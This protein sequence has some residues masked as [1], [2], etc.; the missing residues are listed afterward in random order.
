MPFITSRPKVASKR[1]AVPH[2][3]LAFDKLEARRL[4]AL[5]VSG[6]QVFDV[7]TAGAVFGAQ[8]VAGKLVF[9]GAT[10]EQGL[11]IQLLDPITE[12]IQT[13]EINPGIA[14]SNPT[15]IKVLGN[16]VVFSAYAPGL[17][18]EPHWFDASDPTPTVFSVD[19]NPGEASSHPGLQDSET[20]ASRAPGRFVMAGEKLFFPAFDSAHGYEVRW[21]D[22]GLATPT[23]HTLDVEGGAE[24]TQ[25]TY[26]RLETLDNFVYLSATVGGNNELFWLDASQA[27]PNATRLA[28]LQNTTYFAIA[29]PYLYFDGFDAAIGKE[30]HRIEPSVDPGGVESIDL[31]PGVASSAPFSNETSIYLNDQLFFE[32]T[33]E[34]GL[35]RLWWIDTSLS[36]TQPQRWTGNPS[37]T[38]PGDHGG[39]VSVGDKVFFSAAISL[40]GVELAWVDTAE[41]SIEVEFLDIY[42]VSSRSSLPGEFG[43][44]VAGNKLYFA[45]TTFDIGTEL[46]WIDTTEAVPTL[47]SLDLAAR[48]NSSDPR[49]FVEVDGRVFFNYL[50]YRPSRN[51]FHYFAWIDSDLT[52]PVPN[53]VGTLAGLGNGLSHLGGVPV[54]DR[55]FFLTDEPDHGAELAWLDPADPQAEVSTI[56]TE[57]GPQDGFSIR[58]SRIAASRYGSE[59]YFI[60]GLNQEMASSL[61]VEE[62]FP[63]ILDLPEELLSILVVDDKL[64]DVDFDT[65]SIR[66]AS[67][68]DLTSIQEVHI[69]DD[70]NVYGHVA[71][72]ADRLFFVTGENRV[73]QSYTEFALRWIDIRNPTVVH[74]TEFPAST[75]PTRVHAAVAGNKYYSTVVSEQFGA[76][77]YWFDGSEEA[78]TV[79]LVSGSIPNGVNGVMK[80]VG[81]YLFFTATDDEHGTEVRWLDTTL[82][83]PV[84]HTIDI[85]PGPDSS[86]PY[87]YRPD[88][89]AV[90]GDR[91]G[92]VAQDAEYGEEIRW[93][94]TSQSPFEVHTIDVRSGPEGSNA[95]FGHTQFLGKYLVF[96]AEDPEEGVE[97]HWVDTTEANPTI[98]VLPIALGDRNS[99]AE[100]ID[101]V[102]NHV[103][104]QA[105]NSAFGRELFSVPLTAQT[106]EVEV[107]SE[108]VFEDGSIPGVVRRTGTDSSAL[109]VTLSTDDP[110]R[111]SV[112]T[113]VTI[114]AGSYSAS[115]QLSGRDD[116]RA[117][118]NDFVE[119]SVEADDYETHKTRVHVIDLNEPA[120][121][122]TFESSTVAEGD[123]VD[124]TLTRNSSTATDLEVTIVSE[125]TS[126]ASVPT[127]VTIPATAESITFSVTALLDDIVDGAQQVTIRASADQHLGSANDIV[128]LDVDIPKLEL[129]IE[130]ASISENGT[131]QATISRNTDTTAQLLVGLES[132]DTSEA[133]IPASVT[134]PA[135]ESSSTFTISGVVD[136]FV[137]GSQSVTVTGSV[138][139]F[140]SGDDTLEVTDDD[141]PE[142]HLQISLDSLNEDGGVSVVTLTRNTDTTAALEVSVVSSDTSE[143]VVPATHS[144][145]A[146]FLSTT[147]LVSAVDDQIVDGNQ[148]VILTASASDHANATDSVEILDDDVP[149][150]R[151][152]F[153]KES[154]SENGEITGGTVARNTLPTDDLVVMLTVSDVTE[155]QIQ[156]HITIPAG[157][158]SAAIEIAGVNDDI[159]DGKQTVTVHASADGH[160]VDEFVVEVLDDDVAELSLV[161]DETSIEENGGSSRVTVRRNTAR[162]APLLVSL[163][164]SDVSELAVP[165]TVTIPIGSATVSFFAQAVD[166]NFVDGPS[167]VTLAANASQH[168]SASSS[169]EIQDD[170]EPVLTLVI[171]ETSID[172]ND[173]V[174]KAR[175]TRNTDT[176][177]DLL[178][179]FESSDI[180]E[181]SIPNSLIIPAGALAAETSI[182]GVSDLFVDGNQEVLITATAQNHPT[183][184][185]SIEILDNDVPTL[186]VEIDHLEIGE[187][188]PNTQ[189]TVTRNTDTA[190]ALEV[191]LQSSDLTEASTPSMV[192]IPVGAV[193]IVFNIDSVDD[194]IVDG[195]QTVTILAN[196]DGHLEGVG[197]LVI[198]DDDIAQLALEIDL[199][200]VSESGG[201]ALGLVA[202]NTDTSQPLR[203]LLSSDRTS[204]VSIPAE[205]TIP[206]QENSVTFTITAIDNEQVD[207]T[208]LATISAEAAGHGSATS[209]IE[210]RDDDV[211]EVSFELE[212]PAVT[213]NGES[214]QATVSRNTDTSQDLLVQLTTDRDDEISLPSTVTIPAGSESFV[215]TVEAV[216]DLIVDGIQFAQITVSAAQHNQA[217][218]TLSVLDDDV[219]ELA[220]TIEEN[221]LTE[222]ESAVVTVSR[223]TDTSSELIVELASSDNSET[224]LPEHVA[225]PVGERTATFVMTGLTDGFVDGTQVVQVLATA[226][227]HAEAMLQV[228]IEDTDEAALNIELQ[229]PVIEEN[230]GATFATVTRN[231]T[232]ASELIV[233]I[234][235]EPADALTFP[236]TVTLPAGAKSITFEVL[237]INDDFVEGARTVSMTATSLEH[238]DATTQIE[239]TEDDVPRLTL[240]VDVN[241]I[242]EMGGRTQAIVKRNT[243]APSPLTVDLKSLDGSELSVPA[244]VTIP[245]QA[246]SVAFEI[247][248]QQDG[249]VDGL[250]FNMI[251]A[252]AEGFETGTVDLQ[253]VDD[254]VPQ[255]QLEPLESVFT[256][257]SETQIRVSRN[258]DTSSALLVMFDA[259]SANRLD[260]PASVTIP[261]DES[262]VLFE[263][264]GMDNFIVDGDVTIELQASADA[265]SFATTNLLLTD[266]DLPELTLRLTVSSIGEEGPSVEATLTRN[267]STQLPLLV[268][269][270]SSDESELSLPASVTIPAGEYTTKFFVAP[271]DD[272]I[273]DGTETV[274]INASGEGHP[275]ALVELQVTDNDVPT[276]VLILDE[277]NIQ[278]GSDVVGARIERNALDSTLEVTLSS[279]SS[280]ILTP[281]TVTIPAGQLAASFEIGTLD[282]ELVLGDLQVNLV[283]TAEHYVDGEASISLA[284]DDNWSWTNL[285][286]PFDVNED[287]FVSS[288][289]ALLVINFLNGSPP[290]MLPPLSQRP[291]HF[292]DVSADG[293]ASAVDA[294]MVINELNSAQG[295][296]ELRLRSDVFDFDPFAL[297]QKKKRGRYDI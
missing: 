17:G 142:L 60:R 264:S 131:S 27:T 222:E 118:G 42:G 44:G 120:L 197:S 281:P 228:H 176:S 255:L 7:N 184:Q 165:S 9:A 251:E 78:P 296:G 291:P 75:V 79:R 265:H 71:F 202:R 194:E 41:N 100:A 85:Q 81:D 274:Q 230:G 286:N 280:R 210:V 279:D 45:A 110:S 249:I 196:G 114:P 141:E 96:G 22:T 208:I 21:I 24:P 111:V 221:T 178:V 284:E 207:G 3:V 121:E 244:T 83:V 257:S 192:T 158:M 206:A 174:A 19:V 191:S 224:Q 172:E 168:N 65:E 13:L 108:L 77:L 138:A 288:I 220:L 248:A 268:E 261:A 161:I 219:P 260:Y 125:D 193:S 26:H 80:V 246:A 213:E 263:V 159:V 93:I 253:V 150:L 211:P 128:V 122:L 273:V 46:R 254:D 269:L 250:T 124:A 25:D 145:P 266:N 107:D 20:F 297:D 267:T 173:G 49:G 162:N 73:E 67:K 130:E 227:N 2:R 33:D 5:D 247:L 63:T 103:L 245:A 181:A 97:L 53:H 270:S 167:L 98:H 157:S 276:L 34:D 233:S 292:Y 56:D 62:N 129:V 86:I 70:G 113:T 252:S 140:V 54:G 29:G 101:F 153:D 147:F 240:E 126:E 154:L 4:L 215:F 133:S 200:S 177:E 204:K 1:P 55:F 36:T 271:I 95:Y 39:F 119:I 199:E 127:T 37:I 6:L 106:L 237:S 190:E 88:P 186:F 239:I 109:T 134:I 256:E 163:V 151:L 94:D 171:D 87:G 258:T 89:F 275:T 112:P 143:A 144:I 156:S 232:T 183:T 285:V 182:L 16:T 59:L 164:S 290:P 160:S 283:A 231:T 146:G 223:N 99:F 132:S 28:G 57:N 123:A 201:T 212:E 52:E 38:H 185:A 226:L 282:D 187:Q 66:W 272:G 169:I 152:V 135:G 243:D 236:A 72:V 84:I 82:P 235:A 259:D 218:L 51:L 35:S 295:E 92:F 241:S 31:R 234:S 277:L 242:H 216:D 11:E 229:Q 23:V 294:L 198:Q 293:F 148:D 137:D 61:N 136:G 102:G 238:I 12:A 43:F 225:I 105:S 74:R 117:R 209:S 139:G 15:N 214:I 166:D 149:Q 175:V 262:S 47:H 170:D 203:V 115:F 10:S 48:R 8:E 90:D 289:D 155:L 195:P 287:G 189:G 68:D 205:V 14:G 104:I 91:I 217:T 30:L 64:F 179:T 76:A 116:G 69:T 50:T 18:F 58:S 278:E 40:R 180:S 188:S 32:A